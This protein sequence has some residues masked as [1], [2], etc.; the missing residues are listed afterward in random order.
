MQNKPSGAAAISAL[1]LPADFLRFQS[2]PGAAGG[3]VAMATHGDGR[4]VV[5]EDIT[6]D[7]DGDGQRGLDLNGDGT[8]DLRRVRIRVKWTSPAT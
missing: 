8:T 7:L 5:V 3:T 1:D 2:D 4:M 6:Q